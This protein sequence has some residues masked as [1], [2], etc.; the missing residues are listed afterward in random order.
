MVRNN[1]ISMIEL[2]QTHHIKVILCSVLPVFDFPWN[3]N[4]EP[5]SKIIALNNTLN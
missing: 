5:A 2:A 4:Q 1:I 3:P